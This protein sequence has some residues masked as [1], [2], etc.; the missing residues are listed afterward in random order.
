MS[1]L[2]HDLRYALRRMAQAPGFT[3][4]AVLT[5]ALGIGVNTAMF[6]LVNAAMFGWEAA[7]ED[8]SRLVMMWQRSGD[9]RFAPTPA[10]Y[11]DWE[12]RARSFVRMGAYY[13]EGVNLS[14][15]GDPERLTAALVSPALFPTLG[16]RPRHGRG[17]AAEEAQWGRH[18]V[19][20]LSH[21]LWRQRFDGDPSVVG[22]AIALNGAAYT[23]VGVMPPGCWFTGTR[24]EL[25]L[26]M[27]FPPKDPTNDRHSH[28]LRAVGRLQPGVSIDHARR[29]MEAI[30]GQLAREYPENQGL[31]AT[32]TSL[33]ATVLGDV[34]PA[35]LVLTGAVGL[36][37][38]MTCV[39]LANLLL[40]RSAAREREIATRVALGAGRRRLVQQLLVES[41]CLALIGGAAGLALAFWGVDAGARFVPDEVPR[42]HETG[43][44]IDGYVLVFTL[45]ASLITGVLFGLAPALQATRPDPAEVLRAGGRSA[46]TDPRRRRFRAGL[47]AAQIALAVTLLTGAGLLL[48]S[49]VRLQ[50]VDP[51]IQ[52]GPLLTMGLELPRAVTPDRDYVPRFFEAVLER[53][54]AVPGVVAAGVSSHRPLGG[55]GMSRRFT[56]EGQPPAATLSEVANVSARQE[57]AESLQAIGVRLVRGRLFGR[58][59]RPGSERV[60]IISET[61]ARRFFAG[62]DPIGQRISLD[63]PEH[64]WP[65]A[66]LPPG[67]RYPRWK[68]VGV[69]ADVRYWEPSRPPELVVYVPYLQRNE[70][71]PWAPAYLVVRTAAPGTGVVADLRRAVAQVDPAQPLS[72]VRTLDDLWHASLARPRFHLWLLGAFA[73][74]ALALAA[75]GIYG[76]TSYAVAQRTGEIGIRMALG[77]RRSDILR[78]LI[79]HG[80]RLVFVGLALGVGGSVV[81]TRALSSLLFGVSPRDPAVLLVVPALLAMVA[82]LGTYVP[83]RRGARLDPLVA[84]HQE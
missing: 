20:L 49:F 18:Q 79:G 4:V 42:I 37:L 2:A 14:G 80:M 48:K 55:G 78:L 16:V 31:G 1:T 67:G 29:E 75:L 6:S 26:P 77:A 38:L 17:F 59:D 47:V 28:F 8:P 74:F 57:S 23:I 60:A 3:A 66:E 65:A 33:R 73:V 13:Y 40:A 15:A 81:V 83:A 43:V 9:E 36:V 5:L 82:L 50:Q 30:A 27:A 69:V 11:R 41:L 56:V 35:L 51:G 64:L 53:V 39:N 76:L 52:T 34:Q 71:M 19:A 45:A 72:D 58:Q 61:V 24:A 54:R 46:T 44:P 32:V 84:L 63:S 12:E 10:D 70:T 68:V 21:A 22:Q 25:W 62:Q 7:Y